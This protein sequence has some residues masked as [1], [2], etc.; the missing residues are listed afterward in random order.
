MTCASMSKFQPPP[1]FLPAAGG[2][3][4]H[5]GMYHQGAPSHPNSR[6][7]P[8]NQAPLAFQPHHPPMPLAQVGS[9]KREI[10]VSDESEMCWIDKTKHGSKMLDG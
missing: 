6:P 7:P 2:V 3:A 9:M 4:L 1:L 8:Y 10:K 5:P